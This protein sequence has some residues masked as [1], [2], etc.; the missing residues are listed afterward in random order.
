MRTTRHLSL[1]ADLQVKPLRPDRG[2]EGQSKIC[3]MQYKQIPNKLDF[4]QQINSAIFDKAG[5]ILKNRQFE[6]GW[7]VVILKL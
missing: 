1:P 2:T 4:R 3:E 7:E 5:F 6:N